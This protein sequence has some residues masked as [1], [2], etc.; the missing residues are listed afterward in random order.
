MRATA[1][2]PC[3]AC[4]S[5]PRLQIAVSL[6]LVVAAGLFLRTFASLNRLPLGFVPEPLL[7]ADLNLQANG[8]P[9]RRAGRLD[10]LAVLREG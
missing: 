8:V 4:S 1:A 3:A 10:P 7:D 2:L 6:V 5:W 9:A